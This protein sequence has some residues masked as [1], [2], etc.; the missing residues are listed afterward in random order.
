MSKQ[1]IWRFGVILSI[2]SAIVLLSSWMTLSPATDQATAA[3]PPK[4]QSPSPTNA[5]PRTPS[6]RPRVQDA[7]AEVYRQLPDLPLENQYVNRESG[8]VDPSNTLISRM[9]RYHQAIK[10]RPL[11]YR[12]DWK[13]TLGD[14]LGINEPM[15]ETS[16]PGFDNLKKN[17]IESDRAAISRLSRT[18]RN[19]LVQALVNVFNPAARQ[20]ILTQKPR[21]QPA[22]VAVPKSSPPSGGARLLL[23]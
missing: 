2:G 20:P 23:P 3:E 7:W 13:F 18:Q 16:Y 22:S 10:G 5:S 8:K 9:I 6:S 1:R 12:L 21:P 17:P 4:T 15:V 14:Y 19:A 11:I